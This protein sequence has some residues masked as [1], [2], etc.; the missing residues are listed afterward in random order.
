MTVLPFA[1][2][3]GAVETDDLPPEP[4]TTEDLPPEPVPADPATLGGDAITYLDPQARA[5][6]A[7]V[8][9]RPVV[10]NA[11][12]LANA[13]VCATPDDYA[14]AAQLLEA[15]RTM[16]DKIDAK[17]GPI[18]DDAHKT[19][20]ALTGLRAEMKD[21]IVTAAKAVKQRCALW[22][23]A[24]DRKAREEAQRLAREQAAIERAAAEQEA[25]RLEA[26]GHS[27]AAELVRDDAQHAPLPAIHVPSAVPK[28]AGLVERF[29]YSYRIVNKS[30]IP[31]E[32]WI[33]D[34]KALAAL[35]RAQK[36]AFAV[37]GVEVTKTPATA[38]RKSR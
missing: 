3:P 38:F 12:S 7:A 25:T 30:L 15:L 4:E 24:E 19:H 8:V 6:Q 2:T 36:E 21:P 37:P 27:Q 31:D 28:V 11:L 13:Y 1:S 10:F 20:R 22:R 17:L 5:E 32:F 18:I 34:E 33:V 35:V 14:H 9:L 23:E 29:E 26:D 16:E